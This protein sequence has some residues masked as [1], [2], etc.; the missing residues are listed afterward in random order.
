M[1]QEQAE[2]RRGSKEAQSHIHFHNVSKPLELRQM[3]VRIL[4]GQNTNFGHSLAQAPCHHSQV[5]VQ[6]SLGHSP[7][8]PLRC[9]RLK[10]VPAQGADEREILVVDE[11]FFQWSCVGELDE[12]LEVLD[13]R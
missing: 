7:D 12:R 6:G 4:Q 11:S 9:P 1:E 8:S 13:F 10:V 3:E 2:G 5:V